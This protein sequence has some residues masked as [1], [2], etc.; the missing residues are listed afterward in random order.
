MMNDN[1]QAKIAT[2]VVLG[3]GPLGRATATA[4]AKAGK[5]VVLVN[6]SG[7]LNC[8]PQQTRL[9]AGNLDDPRGLASVLPDVGSVYFCVQ[10]LY[11]R[12]PQEF[13]ALQAS[14]IAIAEALGAKLI[15][16]ENLYGYGPVAEPMVEDMP[17]R[18]NTRKGIVRAAMHD[19]LME[20]HRT[21]AVQVAVARGSDFFGPFVD[22]SVAGARAIKSIIRGRAVNYTGDLDMPHSYT[23]VEDFGRVLA[24]LG[25]DH[26]AIGQVWHVPNADTVSS[27]DFFET[28]FRIAGKKP[29]LAKMSSA[30]M[31]MLGLFIPPMREMVEMTYQFERPFVVNDAKFKHVFGDIATPLQDSLMRSVQWAKSQGWHR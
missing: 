12:W 1:T 21:G 25:I 28:A 27:R 23:F 8:I 16:A 3:A 26:R 13:P 15:V 6:R 30:Q 5:S 11:H 17:L 18:P 20:V 31:K 29:K 19:A 9:I 14:A 22:G 4:L 2:H 10:P 7:K 24:T